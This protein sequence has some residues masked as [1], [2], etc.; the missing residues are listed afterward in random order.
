M[1]N[2][3]MAYHLTLSGDFLKQRLNHCFGGV[4]RRFIHLYLIMKFMLKLTF[5]LLNT[6]CDSGSFI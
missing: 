2:Y 3:R 6:R 5:V 4:I 1:T